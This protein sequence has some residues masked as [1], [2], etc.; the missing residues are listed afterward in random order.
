M[1]VV[2]YNLSCHAQEVMLLVVSYNLSCHAQ[3]VMLLVVSYNLSCHAQEVHNIRQKG[4][5]RV[6]IVASY[7]EIHNDRIYDLLQPYKKGR[8]S[9][10]AVLKSNVLGVI[11]SVICA[12]TD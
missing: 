8:G 11:L 5:A 2:S 9:R 7:V 1:L 10:Y 6:Q 4:S 12:V 3:E